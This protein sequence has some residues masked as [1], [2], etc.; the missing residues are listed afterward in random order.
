[1]YLSFKNFLKIIS[2][3]FININAVIFFPKILQDKYI[4][5][6]FNGWSIIHLFSTC[7]FSYILKPNA[8]QYWIIIFGW[9]IIEQFICPI[10]FYNMKYKFMETYI[11]T[12]SD[13]L[14]AIPGFF[15]TVKIK[16]FKIKK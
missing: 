14:I 7:S 3:T 4:N 9:E 10:F 15:F 2:I 8:I 5:I 13:I 11:D 12:F 6:P 1:M 16:Q